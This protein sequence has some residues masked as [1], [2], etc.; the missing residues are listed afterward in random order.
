MKL[1]NVARAALIG[2]TQLGHQA[3][4]YLNSHTGSAGILF[5][6]SNSAEVH[7]SFDF[8]K[9][10]HVPTDVVV[11]AG[12]SHFFPI[13][14]GISQYGHAFYV[15]ST[16]NNLG[17]RAKRDSDT[18]VE[19]TMN[20]FSG[21]SYYDVDVE[22]GVSLPVRVTDLNGKIHAGCAIDKMKICP[23]QWKHYHTD[24]RLDQCKNPQ[25][26]EAVKF[27][28]QGCPDWYVKSDDKVTKVRQF[29]KN[30]KSALL[31]V[32]G[33]NADHFLTEMRK[34]VKPILMS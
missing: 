8:S 12:E 29:K 25:N 7:V 21:H 9:F 17:A 6:N 31:T 32:A 26:A 23:T 22:R 1:G 13:P 4:D 2:F 11:P 14:P 20:G 28:R 16:P 10:T 34:Q 33:P 3:R 27:F 24:G 18:K 30:T 5:Y 15:G 19:F